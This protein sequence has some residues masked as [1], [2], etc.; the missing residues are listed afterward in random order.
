MKSICHCNT[1][2]IF[3]RKTQLYLL[4]ISITHNK[5]INPWLNLLIHCISARS[6]PKI[7]AIKDECTFRLSNFLIIALCYSSGNCCSVIFLLAAVLPGNLFC[8]TKISDSTRVSRS[9]S[10]SIFPIKK[11][12]N[13]CSKT[14]LEF[15]VKLNNISRNILSEAVDLGKSLKY[16]YTMQC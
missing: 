5:N 13:H 12:I 7:L 9:I 1:H 10:S 2:F 6:A 15:F 3:Q 4:W 16:T 14:F 8:L 11:F